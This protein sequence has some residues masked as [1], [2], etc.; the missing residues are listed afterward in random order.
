MPL[1]KG[2]SDADIQA[3]IKE[4]IDAGHE[5]KQAEAIAYKTAGRSRARKHDE[6]A[7]RYRLKGI[8]CFRAG[9]H[10]DKVYSVAD[11]DNMV[12]LFRKYQSGPGALMRVPGKIGHPDEQRQVEDFDESAKP[13][14]GRVERL[15][16]DGDILKADVGE[17]AEPEARAIAARRYF[18][19]SSEVYDTPPRGIPGKGKMLR[20]VSFLG[21]DVPQ[22][23]QLAELPQPQ[24]YAERDGSHTLVPAP[25]SG[26]H[27]THVAPLPG[28]A[29][30][31]FSEVTRMPF[32]PEQPGAAPVDPAGGATPGGGNPEE[33]IAELAKK[34]ASPEA[35]QGCPPAALAEM[36]RLLDQA[37]EPDGDEMG[38]EGPEGW[39]VP[40]DDEEK[41]KFAATCHRMAEHGRRGF[42][43]YSAT[44]YA[45][46]PE[47][48]GSQYHER[49][50][51]LPEEQNRAMWA[52]VSSAG[53]DS[54]RHITE[55][56]PSGS[57]YGKKKM[58]GHWSP[59]GEDAIDITTAG[60]MKGKKKP[61]EEDAPVK[62][63]ELR[64][65]I[66]AEFKALAPDVQG[67]LERFEKFTE[68]RLRSEKKRGVEAL[69]DDLV[70]QGKVPPR[71]RHEE[72]EELLLADDS[73]VH[74]FAEGGK[75]VSATLYD[76]K[77]AR[78]KRRP[79][80]FAEKMGTAPAVA[81]AGTGSDDPDAEVEKVAA[82]FEAFSERFRRVNPAMTKD[83]YV[84]G[85]R[86]ERKINPDMTA[87]DYVPLALRVG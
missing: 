51:A 15:W 73:T 47:E 23:K 11:L 80:K 46:M 32:P 86:N 83:D 6:K 22:V 9:T 31:C 3:N 2:S 44:K 71:E 16:R 55:K 33:L 81:G 53:G 70:R 28:G 57:H 56:D 35:L 37:G 5:P 36:C 58:G 20:A 60:V 25:V 61:D 65:L 45:E 59:H 78:L 40:K 19:T 24:R 13:A 43:H 62:M 85:F 1:R 30:A 87:A 42:E 67:K 39:P 50:S 76:R 8:E 49:F 84:N 34:G 72:I 17:M 63:S 41:Q 64:D 75:T 69:V 4:L 29:F 48:Q 10:R 52:K 12:E 21:A 79:S 54:K 74:K 38:E 66:R 77:V 14:A 7:P 82:A 27:L 26:F 68:E 18:S